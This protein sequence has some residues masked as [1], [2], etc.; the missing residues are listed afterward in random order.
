M[1]HLGRKTNPAAAERPPGKDIENKEVSGRA[2]HPSRRQVIA[3]RGARF[4]CG[5]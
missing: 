5:V 4:R 2:G 3:L 1:V